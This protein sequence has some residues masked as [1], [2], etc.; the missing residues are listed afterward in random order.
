[1]WGTVT[2]GICL[3]GEC[4]DKSREKLQPD[5]DLSESEPVVRQSAVVEARDAEQRLL[6]YV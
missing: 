5:R 6:L 4:T 3:T 1:M 2:Q